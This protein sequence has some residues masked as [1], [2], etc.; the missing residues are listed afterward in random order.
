[1]SK[2][3]K[4][5]IISDYKDRFVDIDGALVVDI[6][7]I[8]A[9][10]NNAMRLSL[11]EQNIR[12]T[13]IRNS[14]AKKAFAGTHLEAVSPALEGPAALAY[15]AESV[16][17][18]AREL[19][20]WAKKIDKL[21]L[22]GAVLDG[23]YFEGEAGVKRLSDFPTREEAQA[24]VVQLV[25]APAGNVVGGAKGPGGKILGIIKQ[26]QEKLENGETIAKA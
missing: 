14:L 21:D 7:G 24:K 25:L 11:H 2:P 19:V 26:I 20:K 5:M 1:M 8:E 13:V 22:K 6:R 10:D 17:N 12:I 18:V 9:N 15:G 23:T 4:E 3:I 16:V